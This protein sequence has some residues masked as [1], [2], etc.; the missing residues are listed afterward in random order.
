MPT[1]G[2]DANPLY[3]DTLTD[4]QQHVLSMA[5]QA[6]HRLQLFSPTLNHRLYDD[7]TLAATISQQVRDN[8]RMRVQI[9]LNDPSACVARGHRLV[10]LAQKLSSYIEI[11]RT[12]NEYQHL[13]CDY[14]LADKTGYIFRKSAE[15]FAAEIDYH[16]PLKT[17]NYVKQFMEIW[18]MSTREQEFLRLYL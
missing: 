10:D 5:G 9:L 12:C 15:Q 7:I 17:D 6:R 2:E 1:L 4:T 8:R 18:E 13:V 3:S 16:S 11:R 14:L